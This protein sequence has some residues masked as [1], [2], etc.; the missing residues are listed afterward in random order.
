VVDSTRAVAPIYVDSDDNRVKVV[1]AATGSTDVVLQEVPNT[2]NSEV[3]ITTRLLTASD[4]DKTFFLALAAGF[5]VTLPAV[6]AGLNFSFYVQI[7]PSGG[8]Y[9]IVTAAAAQILAGQVRGSNGA[10]GDSET[11]FSATTITFADGASVIGDSCDMYCDGTS[12][13]A[14]C[15]TNLGASGITVTG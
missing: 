10:D 14:R 3:L 13:Y 6:A 15:W 7:A 5:V 9:T 2:S 1:A 11:A 12:W 8:T 4:T